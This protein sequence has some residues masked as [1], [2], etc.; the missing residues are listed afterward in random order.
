MR[1]RG[2]RERRDETLDL[3]V[4]CRLRVADKD[5]QAGG[6]IWRFKSGDEYYIARANALEGNVSLYFLRN[7]H[8]NTFLYVDAADFGGNVKANQWH[9][10]SGRSRGAGGR[11]AV[12]NA[13][14]CA[15]GR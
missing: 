5:D 9:V 14:G 4:R 1:R 13:D 8:R 10:A 7:G 15:C 12:C 11:F 2:N 3:V 6:V